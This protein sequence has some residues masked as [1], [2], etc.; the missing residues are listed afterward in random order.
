ML[1]WSNTATK[2]TM[3]LNE[4]YIKCIYIRY[5]PNVIHKTQKITKLFIALRQ[6]Q[7]NET[8]GSRKAISL[9]TARPDKTDVF[10]KYIN[11]TLGNQTND[12]IRKLVK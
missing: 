1:T 7:E 12:S 10:V 11:L 5:L 2:T 3:L 4:M 9:E 8:N 6:L